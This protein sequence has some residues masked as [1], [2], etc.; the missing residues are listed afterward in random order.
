[1]M[2]KI[3]LSI[4]LG[5]IVFTAGRPLAMDQSVPASEEQRQAGQ[6]QALRQNQCAAVVPSVTGESWLESVQIETSDIRFHERF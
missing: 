6:G 4:A 2:T 5:L 3:S 1:M